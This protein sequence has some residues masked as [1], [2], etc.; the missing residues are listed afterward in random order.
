MSKRDTTIW[1]TGDQCA[2][3]HPALVD[4]DKSETT[5]LMIE[6][7]Q[8][9]RRVKYH[10]LK[11]V[12]IYS[13]MRHFAERLRRDGWKVDYYEE[14]PDF[15][16]A[17]NDFRTKHPG[18]NFRLMQQSEYG[19]TD[20]L[21]GFLGEENT[22]EVLPHCNFISDAKEFERLHKSERVTMEIFY[23]LMR[24]K[25]G[26]LMDASQPAGGFWNYDQKNRKPAKSDM[27]WPR[28]PQFKPDD[29]TKSCM[30]MVERHFSDHPGGTENFALAVTREQAIEVT[31]HFFN[32]CLD[33]FG[34]FQDAMLDGEPYMNHSILSPYINTCLLQPLELC[35]RAEAR[36]RAGAARLASVEGFIRQIIGWR[37]FMNR[38]YWRMMPEYR[39]RNSLEAHLPL[40]DF[41][42]TGETDMRCLRSVLEQVKEIGYAHHIQ[43][44][45][46][47]GN[48]ALIAGLQPEEV[49]DWFWAMFIDAYD[50]VMVPNVIGMS[51]H[52][53]GGYVGTKPY[54]AS[55]NYI[56]KM[57]NYC[58]NCKYS[59]RETIGESACP[60]NSLYWDFVDRNEERFSHNQRMTMMLLGLH[61][62]SPEAR[63]AI[64]ASASQIKDKL[65]RNQMV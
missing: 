18:T 10:K 49:N 42:W 58:S 59:P 28:P 13:V 22:V 19:S 63:A 33:E 53:D 9:G 61:R 43:R 12:L 41:Y 24:R 16:T 4:A 54:A 7:M 2:L 65:R 37:E 44:L 5:I 47:L 40:P 21:R 45:M 39:K 48:F 23:R 17:I 56:N 52:A 64:K 57:S 36:Y 46:I 3:H 55:A 38:V 8:R 30:S 11:L 6:S 35:R 15:P 34:P 31:E 29:I 50:W 25:T 62:K 14:S 20:Y 26:L 27:N 1:I 51:L 32:E 60:F